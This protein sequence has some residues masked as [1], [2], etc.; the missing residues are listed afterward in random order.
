MPFFKNTIIDHDY[1]SLDE[2]EERLN[3]HKSKA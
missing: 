1:I 2:L 3:L